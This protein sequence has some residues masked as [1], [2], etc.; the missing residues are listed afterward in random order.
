MPMPQSHLLD[1]CC[2][3]IQELAE[4]YESSRL[5][6]HKR[7]E[8]DLHLLSRMAK[9]LRQPAVQT[10]S[11]KP[12]S[13]LH[14]VRRVDDVKQA[15]EELGGKAHLSAIYKKTDQIR[16]TA[17]RSVPRNSEAAIRECLETHSSDSERYKS[18]YP[19]LFMMARGRGAGIWAL[20]NRKV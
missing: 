19:N 7:I 16:K 2:N 18:G 14:G 9:I 13:R 11:K 1:R 20:R 15:L 10:H 3:Y 6:D 12:F 5:G 4:I 17:G 8:S